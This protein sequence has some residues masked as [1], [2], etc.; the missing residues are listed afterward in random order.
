MTVELTE[1]LHPLA[2]LQI[3]VAHLGDGG[4]TQI[5]R[6]SVPQILVAHL[7]LTGIAMG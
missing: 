1:N 6:H 2:L 7:A 5:Y 4:L 3:F